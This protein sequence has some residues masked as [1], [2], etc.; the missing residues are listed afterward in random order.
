M[1]KSKK[2][3][4][5]IFGIFLGL[6]LSGCQNPFLQ[7]GKEAVA[8][9]GSSPSEH[10]LGSVYMV[11]FVS[12]GGT[13]VQAVTVPPGEKINAPFAAREY[14]DLAGWY[15]EPG[16][17][18]EWNFAS[19]TVNSNT[20]LYA[21]WEFDEGQQGNGSAGSPF[22]VYNVATLSRVGR[23]PTGLAA[24]DLAKYYLQIEDIELDSEE[25]WIP[26][27]SPANR[28]TGTYNG[29]GRT[30]TNLRCTY[31]DTGYDCIGLFSFLGDGSVVKNVGLVDAEVRGRY[32][33]GGIAGRNY[34]STIQNCFFKGS[35]TGVNRIGGITGENF[36]E[37]TGGL[38]SC[39]TIGNIIGTGY[40]IGGVVGENSGTIMNCYSVGPLV[41][42][43]YRVGGVAGYNGMEVMNCYSTSIVNGSQCVGGI[44]GESVAACRGD[45]NLVALNPSIESII[46]D[47]GRLEGFLHNTAVA[48]NNY[49][50]SGILVDN[51][52]VTGSATDKNGKDISL[53]D[54]N[55]EEW[56]TNGADW[57]TSKAYWNY[58]EE[59]DFK[60]VW[61]W[62]AVKKLPVLR[63]VG[64]Q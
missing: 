49:A 4:A 55:N 48:S 12:N 29:G 13:T 63:N 33:V 26:I 11:S 32:S 42:G 46:G 10:A 9:P 41:Q 31:P 43:E 24:W 21:K 36:N 61:E 6:A 28:F 37:E 7:L 52:I 34:Q 45:I 57:S 17:S 30:I 53:T 19:D 62:D 38:F 64:G 8:S 35:V 27:G 3:I 47:I 23:E 1:K 60:K 44:T 54:Y 51:N 20:T 25:N 40:G 22:L 58:A 50:W 16:L 5:A 18:N 39:Y 2:L 15:K 56:W 59:W 14:F